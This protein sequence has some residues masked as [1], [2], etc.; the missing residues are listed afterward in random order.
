VDGAGKPNLTRLTPTGRVESTFSP[1]TAHPVVYT[2]LLEA[3]GRIV[4][5]TAAAPGV[6]R[7]LATGQIDPLFTGSTNWGQQ[8]YADP[9][10][11]G[12]LTSGVLSATQVLARVTVTGTSV[13]GFSTPFQPIDGP[14]LPYSGVNA[15]VVQP[16]GRILVGGYLQQNSSLGAPTTLLARLTPGGQLDASFSTTLLPPATTSPNW[17]GAGGS[18]EALV[19][20]PDGAVVV[21]GS[22]LTAAGQPVTGLVR[23]LAPT[24]LATRASATGRDLQVWPIPA[25]EVLHVALGAAHPQRLSLLNAL[26]ETVYTQLVGLPELTLST[27]GLARGLYVLRVDYAAGVATRAIVLE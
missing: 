3:T 2:G 7:L 11:G 8:V 12:Y 6:E 20:Q 23:L 18:V 13:P 24:A 9:T 26:G 25:Q 14:A 4:C 19:L 1:P 5:L 10:T 16:D 15:V 17:G 22:F 21:G 27:A